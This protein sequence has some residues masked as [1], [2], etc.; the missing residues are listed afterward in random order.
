MRADLIC[1]VHTVLGFYSTCFFLRSIF[2]PLNH[3]V[4]QKIMHLGFELALIPVVGYVF[5]NLGFTK[6][7]LIDSCNQYQILLK[8]IKCMIN[9]NRF[10]T[11]YDL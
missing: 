8:H 7:I 6:A 11:S 10:N 5:Q 2:Q 4:L 9:K 1:T 3:S